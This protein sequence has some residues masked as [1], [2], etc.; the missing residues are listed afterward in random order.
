MNGAVLLLREKLNLSG[1][2]TRCNCAFRYLL[3][4]QAE[5]DIM[6]VCD[7]AKTVVSYDSSASL[8]RRVIHVPRGK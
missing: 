2:Q 7:I 5:L 8:S 6:V 1:H 3:I 4:R